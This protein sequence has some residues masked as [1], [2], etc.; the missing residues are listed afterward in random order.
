MFK[1]AATTALILMI[2]STPFAKTIFEKGEW[3]SQK[4][5]LEPFRY[6]TEPPRPSAKVVDQ[7]APQPAPQAAQKTP[8][9]KT[10]ALPPGE[11]SGVKKNDVWKRLNDS[12]SSRPAQ[13]SGDMK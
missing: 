11:Q 3:L 4:L 13:Q 5:G 1:L 6:P 10:A 8:A 9:P 12:M 2:A 7:T